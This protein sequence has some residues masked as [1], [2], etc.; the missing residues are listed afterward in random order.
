MG[1]LQ[2]ETIQQE[3]RAFLPLSMR[4]FFNKKGE[5]QINES[6]YED[7]FLGKILEDFYCAIKLEDEE[8]IR[9]A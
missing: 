7:M 9:R 8:K 3:T 1:T 5:N 4:R 2:N 6:G